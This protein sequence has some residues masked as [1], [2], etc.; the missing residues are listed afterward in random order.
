MVINN[1]IVIMKSSLDIDN[2]K[3]PIYELAC[4]IRIYG[5]INNKIP[6][7]SNSCQKMRIF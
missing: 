3:S 4:D 5:S 1:I 7:L 2:I 6:S